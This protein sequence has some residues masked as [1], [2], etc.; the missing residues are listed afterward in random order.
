[1]AVVGPAGEASVVEGGWAAVGVGLDVV[2]VAAVGGFVAAGRV[3][4]VPVAHLDGA[5][6]RPGEARVAGTPR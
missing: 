4:A 3:L 2:D 5:A 1:M 6:Q